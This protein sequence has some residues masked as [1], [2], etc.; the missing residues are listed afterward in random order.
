MNGD[1][2]GTPDDDGALS[3]SDATIPVEVVSTGDGGGPIDDGLAGETFEM[4]GR[5]TASASASAS[6]AGGAVA[7]LNARIATLEAE[8]KDE[9]DKLLRIAADL[10]NLRKRQRREVDDARHDTK[11][12]VLKEMLP[13]V[14]NLERAM[15]ATSA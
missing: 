6:S 15:Q 2:N 9:R 7:E 3:P 14:D 8:K 12:R 11:T 1:S 13:V 5:A 10:E 4:S